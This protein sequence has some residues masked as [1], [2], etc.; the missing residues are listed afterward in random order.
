MRVINTK[1]D[2]ILPQYQKI[3]D[4]LDKRMKDMKRVCNNEEAL[5]IVYKTTTEFEKMFS[6]IVL[7]DDFRVVYEYEIDMC[8]DL[9]VMLNLLQNKQ[10]YDLNY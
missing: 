4:L 8:Y 5:N 9:I 6:S 7:S 10:A 3:I 2:K 1:N